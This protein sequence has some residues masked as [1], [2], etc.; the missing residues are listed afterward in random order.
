MR[1]KM[2]RISIVLVCVGILFASSAISQTKAGNWELSLAG[3][4]GSLQSSYEYSSSG[5]GYSSNYS[6]GG[7]AQS[8]MGLDLR[9]GFFVVDG[10]SLE[11]EIYMLVVEKAKPAYN[12]GANASYTASIPNSP[13]KPFVS[14][15]YGIGNAVPLMQRIMGRS[16]DDM[17][18]PVLRAGTGLKV[19]V[20]KQV[21]LKVEYR[22]ER[23]TSETE[24]S[25]YSYK[26]TTKTT[27][28]MHN[29]LIGFSIFLPGGE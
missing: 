11:P 10:F 15:G 3:N 8:Y 23:Y 18:I 25:Y 13:V 26:S 12:F 2:K 19:F 28:N 20:S 9:A 7:D 24:S 29:I 27:T 16:S 6:N 1:L 4:L 5:G 22:Y 21:A 14:V 17:D